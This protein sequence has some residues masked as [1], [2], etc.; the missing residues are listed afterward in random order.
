MRRKNP[1]TG[2]VCRLPGVA[3]VLKTLLIELQCVNN[4]LLFDARE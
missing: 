4:V 2:A 1:V 3:P